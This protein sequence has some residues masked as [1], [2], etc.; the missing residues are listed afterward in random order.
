M[1]G[2]HGGFL[3]LISIYASAQDATTVL[4]QDEFLS[5]SIHAPTWGATVARH[6][7]TSAFGYHFHISI[8]APA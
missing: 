5:I 4:W 1:E 6:F 3:C 2:E 7:N 8:H